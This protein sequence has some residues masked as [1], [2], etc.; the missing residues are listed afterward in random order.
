MRAARK[1][2]NHEIWKLDGLTIPMPR[3]N[4]IGDLMAMGIYKEAAEKLGKEWWI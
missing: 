3:H 1:G 4:E 2:G